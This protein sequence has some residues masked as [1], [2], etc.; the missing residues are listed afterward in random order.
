MHLRLYQNGVSA[1][2]LAL[3]Y[4]CVY[5]DRGQGMHRCPDSIRNKCAQRSQG[6]STCSTGGCQLD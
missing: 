5:P 6:A 3:W 1:Q 4:K 2:S